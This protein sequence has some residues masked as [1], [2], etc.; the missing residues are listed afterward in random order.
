MSIS[1]SR[2]SISTPGRVLFPN[3]VPFK[4]S[5]P[6]PIPLFFS[7]RAYCKNNDPV[8]CNMPGNYRKEPG[9]ATIF[10]LMP[11]LL[12]LISAAAICLE[13]GIHPGYYIEHFP[14]NYKWLCKC[15]NH[16]ACH[17]FLVVSCK[18]GCFK[19]MPLPQCPGTA[20]MCCL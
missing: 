9:Y 13:T 5:D 14:G 20:S 4:I 12:L 16:N 15:I 2:R 19:K 18:T 8:H 6:E 7:L 3:R 11:D 1:S 17:I 10:L